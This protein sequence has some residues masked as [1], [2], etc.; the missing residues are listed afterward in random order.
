M[1]SDVTSATCETKTLSPFIPVAVSTG[2]SF[3]QASVTPSQGQQITSSVF[4]IQ[5]S[6]GSSVPQLT[7]STFFSS[8]QISAQHQSPLLANLLSKT[9]LPQQLIVSPKLNTR[10]TIQTPLTSIFSHP[11]SSVLVTPVFGQQAVA[12]P[13]PHSAITSR[14]GEQTTQH[15]S[16]FASIDSPPKATFTMP[17]LGSGFATRGSKLT[18]TASSAVS[19]TKPSGFVFSSAESK[20]SSASEP[21]GVKPSSFSNAVGLKSS[22]APTTK[23]DAD[24]GFCV[25]PSATSDISKPKNSGFNFGVATEAAESSFQKKELEGVPF[26]PVDSNLSF[27]SLASKSEQPVFK[28]GKNHIY[29]FKCRL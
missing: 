21:A 29:C 13:A 2:M 4:S 15:T 26:L 23:T 7:P 9:T 5:S 6:A 22:A 14:L 18:S 10:T 1:S 12:T 27:A 8:P 11:Q 16:S 24:P 19:E 3:G 25:V 28:T 17:A 20:P